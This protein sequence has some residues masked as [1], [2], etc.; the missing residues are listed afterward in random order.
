MRRTKIKINEEKTYI[1]PYI[2]SCFVD[3]DIIFFQK[4]IKSESIDF[5]SY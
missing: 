4:N 3:F 2:F 5:L 1:K